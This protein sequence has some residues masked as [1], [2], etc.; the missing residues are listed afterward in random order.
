M[1]QFSVTITMTLCTIKRTFPCFFIVFIIIDDKQPLLRFF[2]LGIAVLGD[3]LSI[4]LIL[5][6]QFTDTLHDLIS[7]SSNIPRRISLHLLSS[8]TQPMQFLVLV[9]NSQYCGCILHNVITHITRIKIGKE[10]THQVLRLSILKGLAVLLSSTHIVEQQQLILTREVH[11]KHA[12]QAHLLIPVN[13]IDGEALLERNVKETGTTPS[14]QHHCILIWLPLQ[15][16]VLQISTIQQGNHLPHDV[17]NEVLGHVINKHIQSVNN[18]SS[19]KTARSGM[20]Q[21]QQHSR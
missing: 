10:G 6:W 20:E 9:A 21:P 16:R 5:H 15:N 12:C 18:L 17:G 19:V 7:T 8:I 1:L 3:H 14:S 13:V 11:I 4:L 2:L